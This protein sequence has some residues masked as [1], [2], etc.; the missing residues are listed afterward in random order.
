MLHLGSR[1]FEELS[2]EVVQ[3]TSFVIKNKSTN[4][5]GTYYRLVDY[6]ESGEKEKK[7]LEGVNKFPDIPQKSFEKIPGI[8]IAYWISRN[9]LKAFE[10]ESLDEKFKG[11]KGACYRK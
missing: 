4:G 3:S 9:M 1:T 10:N 8:P 7:F 6:K 5:S 2:G 11:R